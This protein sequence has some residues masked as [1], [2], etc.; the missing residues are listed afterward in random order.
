MSAFEIVKF[1]HILFAIIAVGF[2]ASYG[3]WLARA[4]SPSVLACEVSTQS[5]ETRS[6]SAPNRPW[7]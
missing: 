7:V 6:R 2:N 5:R 4:A 3:V 1:L